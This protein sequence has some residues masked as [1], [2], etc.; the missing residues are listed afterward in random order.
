MPFFKI[1]KKLGLLLIF[2]IKKVMSKYFFIFLIYEILKKLNGK[3]WEL[4]IEKKY[5]YM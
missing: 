4:Y 5:S 1:K 3:L 2:I